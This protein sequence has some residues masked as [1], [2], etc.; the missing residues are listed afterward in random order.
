MTNRAIGSVW[1][2]FCFSFFSTQNNRGSVWVAITTSFQMKI[3]PDVTGRTAICRV[4]WR[5]SHGITWS[6]YA[7]L[8]FI[9][10]Q[11]Y[12]FEGTGNQLRINTCRGVTFIRGGQGSKQMKRFSKKP[13]KNTV[14]H[15]QFT[16]MTNFQMVPVRL[17]IA[18]EVCQPF[19]LFE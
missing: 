18:R 8:E 13:R 19:C 15:L 3:S 9:M 16:V 1:E 6:Y 2:V 17:Y 5:K 12:T 10:D 4:T 7:L 14:L 11:Q